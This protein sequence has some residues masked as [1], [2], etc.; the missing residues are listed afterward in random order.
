MRIRRFFPG[1]VK[2]I[3]M[4]G[5]SNLILLIPTGEDPQYSASK[6]LLW[7]DKKLTPVG[8]ISFT[9]DAIS[10]LF[11][12]DLFMVAL[13]ESLKCL[14]MKDIKVMTTISTNINPKGLQAVSYGN[15]FCIA[16]PHPEMGKV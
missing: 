14:T 11:A 4:V 1:G 16:T 3:Q 9:S 10:V 12:K 8:E 15:E 2:V 7:D 5:K 6:V 13:K